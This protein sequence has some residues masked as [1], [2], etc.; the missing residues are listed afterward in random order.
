VRSGGWVA[1][2]VAGGAGVAG[3]WL[4]LDLRRSGKRDGGLDNDAIVGM[5]S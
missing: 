1:S 5:Q 3:S 4:R 2:M